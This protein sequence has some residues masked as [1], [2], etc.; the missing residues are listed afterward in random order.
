VAFTVLYR[1]AA[2]AWSSQSTGTPGSSVPMT[3]TEAGLRREKERLEGVR[4]ALWNVTKAVG[5][6]LP[7]QILSSYHVPDLP[8]QN[9]Q[10]TR[11]W[12]PQAQLECFLLVAGKALPESWT[13]KQASRA[14]ATLPL[15]LPGVAN[16]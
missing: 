4:D 15:P 7:L 14:P 6:V 11:Q 3:D 1:T 10:C 12:V 5:G 8:Q 9:A 2:L 13:P 16:S